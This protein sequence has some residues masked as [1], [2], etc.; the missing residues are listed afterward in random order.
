MGESTFVASQETTQ[1]RARQRPVHSLRLQMD[2]PLVLIV[3]SLLVIGLLAVYS[4]S[5][6]FSLREYED[7]SGVFLRQVGFV[8]LG[9]GVAVVL[10]MF[11]Y[12]L[13]RKLAVPMMLATIG[14]LV[15]V[16]I[17][18]RNNDA[19][20]S[21]TLFG[22]SVQPSELAKLVAI[23]YLTVWLASK[24]AQLNS[25]SIGLV[26]MMVILGIT[27][28]IIMIQ[29]DFSAA[30]TVV[31]LGITLFFLA[32][33]DLRQIILLVLIIALMGVLVY[34]ISDTAQER[35]NN[36]EIG[37]KT[38]TEAAYHVKRAFEAV[39]K[40]GLFGVGIG[41]GTTKYMGGLP[42]PWTDSIFAIV[43]E[44]TGLIGASV[45]VLL[46]LAFIWRGTLIAN[47]APDLSGKL[48]AGGVTFWIG[49]EAILN[50]AGLLNLAP[51]AGNAL[52]L[53][54][55]GGSNM[56]ATLAGIGILFNVARSD[57]RKQTD[58]EGRNYRAVVDLRG[59]NGGRRVSRRG[60]SAGRISQ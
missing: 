3:A 32:G 13:Y 14:L 56:V 41:R 19:E 36:F 40:G 39:I 23:I 55:A 24:Q 5:W 43:A 49:F 51:V 15:L 44:E 18:N 7:T 48:L 53:I 46:F 10:S 50:I 8:L 17:L 12:H 2:V 11:D 27:A 52:P 30:I 38:P 29:P 58:T 35:I 47:R 22:A 60:R 16:I 28:A 20:Y 57:H 4:S 33:S 1:P 26:P 42:V 59:R 45:L 31:L 21:R 6:E 37:L 54:S 25:L 34:F 9:S